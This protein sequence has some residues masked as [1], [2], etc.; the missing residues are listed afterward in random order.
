MGKSS[1][2][3][4]LQNVSNIQCC[5]D[6]VKA[7]HFLE[8]AFLSSQLPNF[9]YRLNKIKL[10]SG[11]ELKVAYT[12]LTETFTHKSFSIIKYTNFPTMS[13]Y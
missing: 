3:L 1:K 4:F 12:I 6:Q 7:E 11:E 13:I 9:A 8:F 2:G 5:L 10:D